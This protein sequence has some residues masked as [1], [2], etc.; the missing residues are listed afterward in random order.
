MWRRAELR[1]DTGLCLHG[2]GGGRASRGLEDS[3]LNSEMASRGVESN[4]V[5]R[6]LGHGPSIQPGMRSRGSR[7]SSPDDRPAVALKVD[8][9]KLGDVSVGRLTP[10]KLAGRHRRNSAAPAAFEVAHLDVP[11]PIGRRSP[12]MHAPA[13]PL[14]VACPGRCP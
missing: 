12:S 3:K 2:G 13:C 5:L 9:K 14:R 10:A 8:E 6:V 11:T 4:A 7:R 1:G